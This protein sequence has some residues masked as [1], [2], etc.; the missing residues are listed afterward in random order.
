MP[1]SDRAPAP[2]ARRYACDNHRPGTRRRG[3]LAVIGLLA[4]AG[5]LVAQTCPKTWGDT[6]RRRVEVH[7]FQPSCDTPLLPGKSAVGRVWAFW[8]PAE[9]AGETDDAF[10]ALVTVRDGSGGVIA[11]GKFTFRRPPWDASVTAR[12]GHTFN[13]SFTP[14]RGSFTSLKVTVEQDPDFVGPHNPNRAPNL[15]PGVAAAN[16]ELVPRE[17]FG[18]SGERRV[19][20]I[21]YV[22]P[23]VGPWAKAGPREA[24]DWVN[25]NADA[26]EE[27]LVQNLPVHDVRRE[28]FI[29]LPFNEPAR[30]YLPCPEVKSAKCLFY[31]SG[32]NELAIA[33]LIRLFI[34]ESSGSI[35]VM[36]LPAGHA[37]DEFRGITLYPSIGRAATA[38][39]HGDFQ[40]PHGP[41]VVEPVDAEPWVLAHEVT[42]AFL[43]KNAFVDKDGNAAMHVQANEFQNFDRARNSS[44]PTGRYDGI[45]AMRI[46]LHGGSHSANKHTEEGNGESTALVPLMRDGQDT[47][48]ILKRFVSDETYAK[49]LDAVPNALSGIWAAGAPAPDHSH[50]ALLKRE[51]GFVAAAAVPTGGP[52]ADAPPWSAF[53]A[54]QDTAQECLLVSG[55]IL[56]DGAAVLD[57]PRVATLSPG[58]DNEG[59]GPYRV[60]LRDAAGSVL[61]RRAFSLDSALVADP[62]ERLVPG[63]IFAVAFPAPQGLQQVVLLDASG[64]ELAR[65]ERRTGAAPVLKLRSVKPDP[66]A[67]TVAVQWEPAA[68]DTSVR[69]DVEY[70]PDGHTGWMAVAREI[71]GSSVL[72]TSTGWPRGP[73]PHIRVVASNGFDRAV[74]ESRFVLKQF[75]VVSHL[76]TADDTLGNSD[77]LATLNSDLPA[78]VD[79]GGQ[80]SLRDASGRSVPATTGY[81]AGAGRL[82]LA[83]EASLAPGA[84]YQATVSGK[85]KDRWNNTLGHDV[86]WSFTTAPD[87]APPRVVATSPRNGDITIAPSVRIAITFDEP[88]ADDAARSGVIRLVGADG[89]TVNGA[90]QFDSVRTRL[91][92]APAADLERLTQYTLRLDPALTDRAGNPLGE[93][94]P[95]TFTTAGQIVPGG[96]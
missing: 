96:S 36:L 53:T 62:D 42:H 12:A 35:V 54:P 32:G 39:Q 20:R 71:G 25:R 45:H 93:T 67:G 8:P 55:A 4:A 58:G 9:N 76:P 15:F 17:S 46:A 75:D 90:V 13:F 77:V 94:M 3:L 10:P 27:F 29:A 24:I 19:L 57:P 26:A 49:L 79:V 88:L 61:A 89:K 5:P 22:A 43:G 14:E 78:D 1:L 50:L 40:L 28:A 59:T 92:F 82:W 74:A 11:K 72:L 81:D 7:I 6:P 86:S 85:L 73:D 80:F 37:G 66:R 52:S 31:T 44:V 48:G 41:V 30:K 91:L 83:P 70:S 64:K 34:P 18:A 84:T 23:L 65:R 63:S 60:E 68:G 16:W 47:N 51:A 33:R 2:A 38:F 95:V 69:F 87:K 21:S 56:P